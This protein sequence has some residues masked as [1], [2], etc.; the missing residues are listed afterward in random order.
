MLSEHIGK[1]EPA[2]SK[3]VTLGDAIADS[4]GLSTAA[5]RD[6]HERAG[7]L[8][9]VFRA[10]SE[11]WHSGDFAVDVER[12]GDAVE[13][14]C[15]A[16]LVVGL[17]YPPDPE[18]QYDF[19]AQAT[20]K[21]PV[22]RPD[23]L[24]SAQMASPEWEGRKGVGLFTSNPQTVFEMAHSF[25]SRYGRVLP[26]LAAAVRPSRLVIADFDT[27]DQG[28]AYRAA[29]RSGHPEAYS[30]EPTV[31]T[32]GKF[33]PATGK[34]L[35]RDGGHG[36]YVLPE[37]LEIDGGSRPGGWVVKAED[38]V[39]VLL[40]GS[41]RTEGRYRFAGSVGVARS[42]LST[43]SSRAPGKA[44]IRATG[45]RASGSG[46][47]SAG[48]S[49]IDRWAAERTW[50][51]LLGAD[52]W[53]ET[54]SAACG[55][56]CRQWRHPSASSARSAIAHG[57]G[58]T[59]F[60]QGA[61]GHWP[62][63]LFSDSHRDLEAGT[64]TV[65]QYVLQA[66]YGGDMSAFSEGEALVDYDP[67]TA[68]G[69]ALA[70]GLTAALTTVTAVTTST[71]SS[72]ATS[73]ITVLPEG[74]MDGAAFIL[75]APRIPPAWWG[76]GKLVLAARGEATMLCGVTGLGKTT[77]AAQ[78]VRASL[79][80]SREVL[81]QPVAECPRVL[82]L[83]MDRPDQARRAYARI[84]T[85]AD[86][87]VLSGR[88]IFWPGPPPADIAKQPDLLLAICKA[89]GLQAGD[90]LIVDSLKDAAI[91]LSEDAVGAGYN[92]SR[93]IVLADG[94]DVFEL[95]HM[96]KRGGDGT[97]PP[98]SLADIYGSTWLSAG[99]GS[100]FVLSGE[101]GDAFVTMTH[102][103]QPMEPFGPV[104]IAHDQ[105]TGVSA[106]D[107]KSDVLVIVATAGSA[108][109][110][111]KALAVALFGKSDPSRN[112]IERA[113]RK[114]SGLVGKGLVVEHKGTR[115]GGGG[116]RTETVWTAALPA[117]TAPPEPGE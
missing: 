117:I 4:L 8:N 63:H 22:F 105:D 79:G 23:C 67:H 65:F 68:P 84:F 53:T 14:A 48:E 5:E 34:W 44:R 69:K 7:E 24:T 46:T 90:R 51:E 35:H 52:G 87:S 21:S 64:F 15:A 13:S 82:V 43:G 16:G 9:S 85:E 37:G 106:V 101:S 86:R 1:S 19:P 42:W 77:I 49:A 57:P 40:P 76:A 81:G 104:T 108:G 78:L 99:A 91:G 33:D 96:V 25:V 112:E 72:G 28:R 55:S 59:E 110:T 88:L 109:I 45:H 17:V 10:M 6:A 62:L 39:F 56:G 61:D 74:F 116:A 2:V 107:R 26:N 95:H 97:S 83:A 54:G 58:C 111:A 20:Q 11:G 31:R 73:G 114:L 47:A 66:R 36:Y 113:R 89:A 115:G 50:A 94:I 98:K 41:K 38:R 30:D 80:L 27:A 93:Q 18:N 70:A 60:D 29:L 103:K 3:K 100:V 102:L 32:P 12:F 75:D 71:T 92:R